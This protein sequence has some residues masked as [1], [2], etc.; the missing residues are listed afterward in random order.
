LE[1]VALL[2]SVTSTCEGVPSGS[3]G[4]I[5]ANDSIGTVTDEEAVDRVG[6]ANVSDG[7]ASATK[8]LATFTP[9]TLGDVTIDAIVLTVSRRDGIA[10]GHGHREKDYENQHLRRKT[11]LCELTFKQVK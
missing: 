9:L 2:N 6:I 10:D 1:G 4:A 5:L 11:H 7:F 8:V 3:T